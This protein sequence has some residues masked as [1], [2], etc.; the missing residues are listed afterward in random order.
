MY[1]KHTRRGQTQIVVKYQGHPELDSG[2]HLGLLKRVRFQIKFG[3]TPLFYN[4]GFTLIELLVVVLIIGILAA[5]ALP[6]YQKAVLKANLSKGIPLVEA[7]WAAQQV[8][9]LTNGDFAEDV[10]D[11]DVTIPSNASCTKTQTSARSTYACSYGTIGMYD[12]KANVEYLP[13]GKQVAYLHYLKDL[14][15]STGTRKAGERW[16]FAKPDNTQAQQV[17]VGMGGTFDNSGNGWT[18]YK[19]NK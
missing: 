19:L 9:K 14:E 17:C 10:D 11:L 2:S 8:Y 18:R 12:T 3:M 7:L 5:V 15:T 13:I 4:R 16:C 6:Q 1:S